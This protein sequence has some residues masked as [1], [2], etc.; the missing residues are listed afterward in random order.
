M[1]QEITRV[2]KPG[3][4]VA[5][6]DFIFTDEC[7]ADLETYG[8]KAA[9]R[10]DGSLSFWVSAILNFGMVRTYHVVGTKA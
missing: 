6:V 7:V 9:R 4:R 5:L 10:R 3:G 8:V 1:M 2:L